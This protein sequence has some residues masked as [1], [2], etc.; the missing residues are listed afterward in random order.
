MRF[1][2]APAAVAAE[3][4]R[5]PTHPPPPRTGCSSSAG[6]GLPWGPTGPRE[7]CA[8]PI[9]A[10]LRDVGAGR[11]ERRGRG[12]GCWGLDGKSF[13]KRSF[14]RSRR[15]GKDRCLFWGSH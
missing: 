13:L 7:T 14:W 2:G 5:T 11:T 12:R 6:W 1:L 10:G 8:S 9:S 15:V 3:G 4:G